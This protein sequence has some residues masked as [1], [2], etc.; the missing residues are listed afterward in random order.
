MS[1]S[2][3]DL[4]LTELLHLLTG[5]KLS[6]RELL[7]D[8]LRRID[9]AEPTVRAFI[10]HT[11]EL[12]EEAAR[13]ADEAR[14]TGEPVGALAGVPVALKDVFLTKGVLTT[15]GS[16]VLAS[17]VPAEDAAVWERLAAAGAGMLGKTTTHEFAYG[18][19]S[20]PTANPWDLRRTPGGSSGGSAAALASRMV[21]AATGTDTG[22]SLRIPAAACGVSTLRSA[23]GRISRYGVIPLSP[24]FDVAG[25]MARRMLDISILMR[26]LAGPDPRDPASRDEPIPAYPL[27]PPR[28]LT[29]VRIG[30]PTAMSWSLVDDRIARVCREALGVLVAR[31]A[32]L[33]DI[34]HPPNTDVV[35]EKS[36]GVFDTVNESEAHQIHDALVPHSHLYTPQVRER[37]RKGEQIS[38]ERY[39][40]ALRLRTQWAADW[41]A[42]MM[43]LRLDAIA[44]PTIDAAPPLIDPTRPPKGPRIRLSVPWSIAD[45]PALSVPAGFDN[46]G[47]PA[48]LSLAGLP[49]R[50]AELVGL[51]ILIDEELQLWR[52]G[53]PVTP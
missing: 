14:A 13:R 12:A 27:E 26:V 39:A 33:V 5:R 51:G 10:T 6:A 47:L 36:T 15:A 16:Q 19:A 45:F 8:C 44:H 52:H 29:G 43:T 38:P 41:R 11:P 21:P 20:S 53:P 49:E 18:T 17:Y 23:H 28:D 34:D 48:G 30:L 42:I 25:P 35:L 46:R 3:A 50:E 7:A 24:T 32:V 22:G 2:A 1:D 9:R 40:E 4:S 37:V 31:G